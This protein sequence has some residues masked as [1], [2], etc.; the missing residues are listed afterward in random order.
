LDVG[1]LESAECKFRAL[2]SMVKLD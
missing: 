1:G 2:I